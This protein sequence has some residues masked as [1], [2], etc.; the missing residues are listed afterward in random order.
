LYLLGRREYSKKELSDKLRQKFPQLHS[1]E[2]ESVVVDL[3]D[4][5][6]QSDQRFAESFFR[7]RVYQSKG[8]KA[9]RYELVQKGISESTIETVFEQQSIDWLE[10]IEQVILRK[11]QIEQLE[12]FHA[13]GKLFQFLV[14]KGFEPH[15][16]DK[17]I[18]KL[19]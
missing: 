3:E 19:R 8:P 7:S 5:G 11:V 13:R 12:D 15:Q 14:R 17:S 2:I 10:L 6:W 16:I 1:D 4:R 18:Q 9:I